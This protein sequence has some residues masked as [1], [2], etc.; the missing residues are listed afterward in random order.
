MSHFTVAVITKK[1]S[2]S[3][4]EKILGP[5]SE[6]LEVEPYVVNDGDGSH[7]S[8]Y[9]PNSKWDW[10]EIGGRWLNSLLIK[11][12]VK[13]IKGMP[14]LGSGYLINKNAPDGYKWTNGAKIKEIEFKLMEE[15]EEQPFYT[16]A[17]VDEKGWNEQGK[18]GWW[19]MND[20]TDESTDSYVKKFNE[21]INNPDNQE[22]YITIVDCH[23]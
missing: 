3:E 5:Y 12:E 22:K 11:N 14:G 17:L 10:Y 6:N 20:A 2:I 18:M 19:A 23:I 15:L 16:W 4:I 1:N 9:N 7:T 21:Y 8:T 13:G